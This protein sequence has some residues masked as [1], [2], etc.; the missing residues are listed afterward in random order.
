[1]EI[2]LVELLAGGAR[3]CLGNMTANI[4]K[5]MVKMSKKPLLAWIIERFS[6]NKRGKLSKRGLLSKGKKH[7]YFSSVFKCS[8]EITYSGQYRRRWNNR[9]IS[10][11]D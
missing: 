9:W 11:S 4:S 1:M 3:T 7:H 8:A 10:K 5:A 6:Q 2:D